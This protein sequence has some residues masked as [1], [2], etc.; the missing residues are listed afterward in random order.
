M[1]CDDARVLPRACHRGTY[2]PA[3][4]QGGIRKCFVRNGLRHA[5]DRTRTCDIRIRNPMLY[6]TELPAQTAFLRAPRGFFE[7]KKLRNPIVCLHC[8]PLTCMWAPRRVSYRGRPCPVN[9]GTVHLGIILD[10]GFDRA[11]AGHF[12]HLVERQLRL[13]PVRDGRL[14]KGMGIALRHPGPP[15][16]DVILAEEVVQNPDR[17]LATLPVPLDVVIAIR[18]DHDVR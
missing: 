10:R 3:R 7:A 2:R 6:P 5:P 13:Q 17:A 15:A 4:G 12:P 1:T 14:A 16:A 18:R 8:V 11:M 9:R